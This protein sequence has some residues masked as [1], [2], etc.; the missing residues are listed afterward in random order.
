MARQIV[1]AKLFEVYQAIQNYLS[2]LGAEGWNL[3]TVIERVV[4]RDKNLVFELYFSK[5][6]GKASFFVCREFLS[7]GYY[8]A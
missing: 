2:E 6:R 4:D 3:V 8:W 7:L 1:D 5:G